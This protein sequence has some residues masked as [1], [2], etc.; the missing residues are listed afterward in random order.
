MKSPKLNLGGLNMNRKNELILTLL[1]ATISVAPANLVKAKEIKPE[2]ISVASC[3]AATPVQGITTNQLKPYVL[4]EKEVQTILGNF[5]DEIEKLKYHSGYYVFDNEKYGIKDS[6]VYVMISLGE[7]NTT[8]YGIKV[9]SAEDIEGVSK[10]TIQETKPLP[11]MMVGEV[12]TYPYIIVKFSQGTPN[13]KV[14]TD[15]GTELFSLMNQL[16]LEEKD[17]KNLKPYWD[18]SEDK[19]WLITFKKDIST[20]AVND[21]TI[22][23]RD[24]GG[25]KVPVELITGEDNKTIKIVP[26][27]KYVE[28]Q[29]YYLFISNKINLQKDST[30]NTKGYRMTFSIKGDVTVGDTV[31]QEANSCVVTSRTENAP[32]F[33]AVSNEQVGVLSKGFSI[34]LNDIKDGKV[35]FSIPTTDAAQKKYYV[36]IKYLAKAYKEP[37]VIPTIISTDMIK[38]KENASIYTIDNGV[39]QLVMKTSQNIDPMHYIMKTENGY[40]FVLAN[41]VVYVQPN[42]VEL[43]KE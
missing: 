33:D 23:V 15:S 20:T 26:I 34:N 29:T 4:N 30:N 9:V 42:D 10:I 32:V 21:D 38:I 2:A 25:R 13:V 8:G 1:F 43:I 5:S 36:P 3:L 6:E 16:E 35:Y 31:N 39:K 18:V 7:R 40:E 22:Y 17:W 11:D 27:E 28:G 19:E 37:F 24:S 14:V 41:N 12:V